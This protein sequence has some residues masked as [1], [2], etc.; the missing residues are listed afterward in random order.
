MKRRA[1]RATDSRG[2]SPTFYDED[3]GGVPP[4]H[5][6]NCGVHVRFGNL[7][8]TAPLQPSRIFLAARRDDSSESAENIGVCHEFAAW[9]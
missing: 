5:R 1:F 2:C 6:C 7:A 8:A 9:P 4:R 3:S